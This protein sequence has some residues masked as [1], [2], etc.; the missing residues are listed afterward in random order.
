[1]KRLTKS[2]PDVQVYLGGKCFRGKF[3]RVYMQIW[4]GVPSENDMWVRVFVG[5]MWWSDGRR[6]L[7]RGAAARCGRSR[8]ETGRRRVARERSSD[9]R[10]YGRMRRSCRPARSVFGD[11]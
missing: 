1:M 11:T 9:S 10:S 3:V 6:V 2:F 7:A 4:L 8:F 5:P